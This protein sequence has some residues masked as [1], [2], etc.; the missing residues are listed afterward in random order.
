MRV[1]VISDTDKDYFERK[2]NDYLAMVRNKNGFANVKIE[3]S[4]C[5][6][7]DYDVTHSAMIIVY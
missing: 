2:V 1:K 6:H 5:T 4:T 7:N 3:Y